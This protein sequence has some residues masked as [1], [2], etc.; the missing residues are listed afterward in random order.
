MALMS[1]ILMRA[2]YRMKQRAWKASIRSCAFVGKLN[3]PLALPRRGAPRCRSPGDRSG[4]CGFMTG[5][6]QCVA[7]LF[8]LLDTATKFFADEFAEGNEGSKESLLAL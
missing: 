3:P 8:F 4:S 2:N 7:D 5:F 6:A 1:S